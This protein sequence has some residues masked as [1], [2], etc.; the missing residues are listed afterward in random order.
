MPPPPHRFPY[1]SSPLSS[2]PFSR[3][4]TA[5]PYRHHLRGSSPDRPHRPAFLQSPGKPVEHVRPTRVSFRASAPRLFSRHV[6]LPGE[7]PPHTCAATQDE[8]KITSL[9]KIFKFTLVVIVE[10]RQISLEHSQ[11]VSS[12][13]RL[14]HSV[15]G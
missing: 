9:L 10:T 7:L 4:S 13:L 11:F 14:N 5:R 15:E 2:P 3:S 12:N 6:R 1:T 8:M